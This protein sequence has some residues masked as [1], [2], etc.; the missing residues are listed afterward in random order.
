[1]GRRRS[2]GWRPLVE[3]VEPRLLMAAPVLDAIADV[4]V[5]T[6]KT[7]FV[8]I[9]AS[10]A[11][12]D[13]LSYTV[14]S[15]GGPVT[16][17]VRSGHSYLDINVA[18]YGH[19]VFQLFDDIAPT[20]V[21]TL[22]G[23]INQGYYNNLTFHRVVPSFV[24]Q[25]GDPKGDGTGGPG[26][27]FNDEFNPQAIFSGDGQLAMANSGRDTN[28]SQFFVTVGQQRFLDFNHT[29]FGQLVRGFDV[30]RSIN[31][32]P[33]S[34]ANNTPTTPIVITSASIV[35]D[36]TDTVLMLAAPTAGASH[37]TVTVS[38]GKGGTDSKTF[39]V[40]SAA[41]S[42]NDPPI[43]GPVGDKTTL[44]STPIT[45]PLSSIDLENDAVT[46]AAAITD[47]PARG[48]FTVTGNVVTVT[49]NAGFTGD[50]H[51]LVG[52]R[53]TNATSRGSSSDLFD[54]QSITIHVVAQQITPQGVTATATAGSSSGSQV[55]AKFSAL[56][57]SPASNFAAT[58]DWG[59]GVKSGGTIVAQAD[60]SFAVMGATTYASAG[61]YNV[62]VAIQ[63]TV[64]G[65][66]ATATSSM[67]VAAPSTGGGGTTPPPSTGGG[68]TTPPVV[69][70][71][72]TVGTATVTRNKQG[73]ITKITVKFSGPLDPGSA[74]NAANYKVTVGP[75]K[76]KNL[77]PRPVKAVSYDPATRSVSITPKGRLTIG[78]PTQ[79]RITGVLDSEGRALNTGKSGGLYVASIT[80][81]GL[82][83]L[84]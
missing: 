75:P 84:A 45:I 47:N 68:T 41:D 33:T 59:N 49:P 25:G 5:P 52:V 17:T 7:R 83:T 39:Q 72:V 9:T 76:A 55:V 20:T 38:D 78:G 81:K 50:I 32:A 54:K 65:G 6:T 51:L 36:K 73:A 58:I 48:T 43:L 8:P 29:I 44:A 53:Q 56:G 46:Y 19:M 60:G 24:I 18:N 34:G 27:T 10:D 64:A 62:S 14:T 26:F 11:D 61:T 31:S 13:A 23:L 67:Q 1:M 40:T 77:K 22:T 63:D 82:K 28:G 35:Q 79:L 80:N 71:L 30:L 12:G 4:S 15:D 74:G 21:S 57:N 16:T 69:Q 70:P 3:S 66:Q 42:T 37:I 2:W